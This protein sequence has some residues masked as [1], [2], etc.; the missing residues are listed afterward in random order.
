MNDQKR[1]VGSNVRPSHQYGKA[2]AVL[3]ALTM[4]AALSLAGCNRG[5]GGA[6]P[7]TAITGGAI[8]S[9]SAVAVGEAITK[10][11]AKTADVTGSLVALQD[12]VVGTKIAGRLGSVYFHEGEMVSAGQV[13]AVM[14]TVDLA[15][16]VQQ[17]HA[18]V[19]SAITKEQQAIVALD[20][21]RNTLAS[22]RTTLKWTDQTTATAVKSA[23]AT[24][25]TSKQRLEIVKQGARKQ[26]RQ[27]AQELVK[28]AKANY[29]KA[30]S[31]LKRYQSLLKEQAVS[32][33][34]V[35]QYQAAFD[36]ALAA[37]NSAQEALSLTNEGARPEDIRTAEL[38]V[39]FA[40]EALNR[41]QS[42]R[43]TV[44]LRREDIRNAEIGVRS[45]MASIGA[46]K[47][48]T[49]VAR[50]GLRI[51]EE[52]LNNS[53]IKSPIN[54]Y[55]AERRAEP[56]QQLGGGGAVMRIVSPKSVYFQAVLSESQFNEVRTGLPARITIDALPNRVFNGRV[57]RIL[58]VA[59]SAARSFNVRIDFP[60]DASLRPQMFARGS[61]LIDTHRNA[62]LVPK[63]AVLFDPV[64]NR[65]RV[66]VTETTALVPSSETPKMSEGVLRKSLALDKGGLRVATIAKERMV[67]IGY[68]DPKYAEVLS[69]VKPGDKVVIAGQSALQDGD[70]IRIQ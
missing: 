55:V 69:G 67:K 1:D 6:A 43:A 70:K 64:N 8:E 36:G 39:N 66:F 15:A 60:S 57:T 18:N 13:V 61:I 30:R 23:A 29:D 9:A 58:P 38:G 52:S 68:S 22:A 2:P 47:A 35:D 21:A 5:G 53:Y 62:T 63:D 24:L 50:A 28:S 12:V 33:S 10:D 44:Q 17:Q 31:D 4:L 3:A 46:A 16:Q 45:A 42:D 26:E 40:Q 20:Q 54:G 41:A 14:D 19:D 49:A 37:Y 32:Q 25:D 48:G 51:A 59:S 7:K 27:Q 11:I 34:Q 56:G 65:T